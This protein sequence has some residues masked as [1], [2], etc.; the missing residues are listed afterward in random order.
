MPSAI[1]VK[2]YKLCEGVSLF[3]LLYMLSSQKTRLDFEPH[4]GV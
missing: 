1:T 2:V 4:G 3:A